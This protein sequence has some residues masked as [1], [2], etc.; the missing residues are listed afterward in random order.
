L[1]AH[2]YSTLERAVNDISEMVGPAGDAML[3]MEEEQTIYDTPC[4]DGFC[5]LIS[6]FLPAKLDELYKSLEDSGLQRFHHADIK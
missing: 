6:D 3:L 2:K 4:E 5:G 1:N